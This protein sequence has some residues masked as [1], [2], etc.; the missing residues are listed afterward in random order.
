MRYSAGTPNLLGGKG[1]R[2]SGRSHQA[3]ALVGSASVPKRGSP[4]NNFL[5]GDALFGRDAEP[6]GGQG[7]PARRPEPPSWSLGGFGLRAEER[8]PD[9]QFLERGCAIRQGRRTYRGA[10]D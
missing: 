3:G 8:I 2:H 7:T 4:I 6:T 9:Q 5:N 10:R 1:L